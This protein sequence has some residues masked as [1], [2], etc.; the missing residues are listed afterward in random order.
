M[1]FQ[2]K[3]KPILFAFFMSMFMA[4][5]VSGALTLVNFGFVDGLFLKWMRGFMIAWCCAFP[6]VMLVAPVARKIADSL[7]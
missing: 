2:A 3:Y 6:A 1:K 5:I 7:T 4:F